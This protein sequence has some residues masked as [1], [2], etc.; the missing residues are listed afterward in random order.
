M[1]PQ[2]NTRTARRIITAVICVILTAAMTLGGSVNAAEALQWALEPTS[3]YKSIYHAGGDYWTVTDAQGRMGLIKTDGTVVVPFDNAYEIPWWGPTIIQ[4]SYFLVKYNGKYGIVDVNGNSTI[5]CQYDSLYASNTEETAFIAGRNGKYGLVDIF[6][7]TLIPFDYSSIHSNMNG[8]KYIIEKNG[9]Y[10]VVNAD[11][12]I[13]MP[14]VYDYI[15]PCNYNYDTDQYVIKENEKYGITDSHGNIIVP[16]IYEQFFQYYNRNQFIAIK[17]GKY[18]VLDYSGNVCVPFIYSNIE[19]D[20]AYGW[21]DDLY[22]DDR[23]IVSIDGVNFGVIDN[24]GNTLIPL[25]YSFAR[26]EHDTYACLEKSKK[27]VY[28]IQNMDNNAKK[29]GTVSVSGNLNLPIRYDNIHNVES[30]SDLICAELNGFSCVYD[31]SGNIVLQYVEGTV[32]A[33]KDGYFTVERNSNDYLY[34]KLGKQIL[35]NAYDYLWFGDNNTLIATINGASSLI[36]YQGNVIL[37]NYNGWRIGDN[38]VTDNNQKYGLIDSLGNI[39][40][41]IEYNYPDH[42][43]TGANGVEYYVSYNTATAS[44]N[45]VRLIYKSRDAVWID[46]TYPH[47]YYNTYSHSPTSI[48]SIDYHDLTI[49]SHYLAFSDGTQSAILRLGALP[50]TVINQ[51]LHTDIMCKV[52]GKAIRSYNIDGNTAIVAEDLLNYG[53]GVTWDGE[54]RTLSVTKGS[55]EAVGMGDIPKDTAE[56]GSYA[57]DVYATDIT[58]YVDGKKVKGYNIGGYTIIFVDDLAPFGNISWDGNA[59]EIA[60]EFAK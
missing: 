1:K 34:D 24:A 26:N 46:F 5:P 7:N 17:D 14:I 47:D 44:K 53:F 19:P 25:Q 39:V 59:R 8:S 10:G 9:Y 4:D 60:F 27:D 2:T 54:A 57:M 12:N 32:R 22:F 48:D 18:G 28:L 40:V 55:G 13:I 11:G 36:D 49:A 37:P 30:D 43:A 33:E 35:Q 23:Y 3:V 20:Y 29:Y 21:H 31:T 16:I 58:T 51:V 56:V 52:G 15:Y 41:P 38:F 6:N 50:G 45:F 42:V